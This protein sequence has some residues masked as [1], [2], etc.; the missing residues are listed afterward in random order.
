MTHIRDDSHNVTSIGVSKIY[1]PEKTITAREFL[2]L[3]T[4]FLQKT[5]SSSEITLSLHCPQIKST[6][7]YYVD[8]NFPRTHYLEKKL[9]NPNFFVEFLRTRVLYY[10]SRS[11]LESHKKAVK[12]GPQLE[13]F[14]DNDG[15]DKTGIMVVCRL[16]RQIIVI[17]RNSCD[18]HKT[19][20]FYPHYL[21]VYVKCRVLHLNNAN[22]KHSGWGWKTA[23]L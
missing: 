14:Q 4:G 18:E 22:T 21:S 20:A 10:V 6:N 13:Y 5:V 16:L 3:E 17:A 19:L 11:D 23:S 2:W 1:N 7:H 12:I 9:F 8:K 15:Y